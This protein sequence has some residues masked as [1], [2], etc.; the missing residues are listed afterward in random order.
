MGHMGPLGC[1]GCIGRMGRETKVLH[2][3]SPQMWTRMC[4]HR[5]G[6]L[7][8]GAGL[9]EDEARTHASLPLLPCTLPVHATHIHPQPSSQANATNLTH[10]HTPPLLPTHKHSVPAIWHTCHQATSICLAH[11]PSGTPAVHEGDP[12][13]VGTG[14]RD[15]RRQDGGRGD[16]DRPGET[17]PADLVA[18]PRQA[19]ARARVCMCTSPPPS[20]SHAYSYSAGANRQQVQNTCLRT[21]P[22]VPT[23]DAAGRLR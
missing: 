23:T 14:D 19:M 11:L 17:L 18:I 10:T 4:M 3:C 8:E 16:E 21:L 7:Q 2:A 13:C 5:G 20:S 1:I 15:I 12:D 9:Q 22:G 6:I